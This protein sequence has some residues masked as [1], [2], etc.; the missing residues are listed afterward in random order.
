M[1]AVMGA[2]SDGSAPLRDPASR[3]RL[4]ALIVTVVV[5]WPLLVLAEFRPWAQIGRA[6][7]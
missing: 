4:G 5:L 3:G 2:A 6:H 7:V 1:S